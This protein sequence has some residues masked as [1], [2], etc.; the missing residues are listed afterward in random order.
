M[1]QKKLKKMKIWNIIQDKKIHK[2]TEKEKWEKST[3]SDRIWT[4]PRQVE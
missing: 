3:D 2:N 4:Y 1:K